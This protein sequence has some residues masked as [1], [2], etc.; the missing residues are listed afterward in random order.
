MARR[1]G[2]EY[3]KRQVSDLPLVVEVGRLELHGPVILAPP[4]YAAP[5]LES[6]R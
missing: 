2:L 3:A 5:T 1:P 4:S 6:G